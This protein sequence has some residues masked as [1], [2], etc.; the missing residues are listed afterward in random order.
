MSG[1]VL[2]RAYSY[3]RDRDARGYFFW[4]L[5]PQGHKIAYVDEEYLARQLVKHLNRE[6]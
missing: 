3:Q 5:D 4:I 2:Q 6:S 1:R